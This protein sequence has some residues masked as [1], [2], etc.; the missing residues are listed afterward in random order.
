MIGV[1]RRT[2]VRAR[3][4]AV[5]LVP[6]AAAGVIGGV[7]LQGLA[8]QARSTQTVTVNGDLVRQALQVKYQAADWNGWQTAYAFDA[9]RGVPD[10]AADT[11][12]S[13]TAFLASGKQLSEGLTALA[14]APGLQDDERRLL[15]AAQDAVA[16]F[17][18]ADADV[19]AGYRAGTSAGRAAANELVIGVEI[20]NYTRAAEAVGR[21][22]DQLTAQAVA[23]T[24]QARDD[25][26][27]ARQRVAWALALAV[28]L[29][30][31]VVGVVVVSITRPLRELHARLVD[32]TDG[33]G[34]L[35]A[36]L[37]ETGRD[38]IASV[39]S[40]F[41]RFVRQLADL[42]RSTGEQA[43]A[44][45]AATEELSATSAAIATAA[46]QSAA[47]AQVV[48]SA[49][50]D[51]SG[52]VQAAA[53]GSEQMGAAILEISQSANDASRV[54]ADAVVLAATT[55]AS[56][57]ALGQASVQVGDF[58]KTIN[59]IA[60]QTNLLALNATIEAARA[61]ESGKGFAVVAGEVKELA[62]ET[63]RATDDIA[64]RVQAIQAGTAGAAQAIGE[65][66]AVIDQISQLQ[67]TIAAAVEEQTATTNEMSRNIGRSAAGTDAIAANITDMAAASR[68]TTEGAS[69]SQQAVTE[70][71]RMS[72]ELRGLVS[73]FTC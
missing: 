38:E 9:L 61:G 34:D 20:E 69:Q 2:S 24:E 45:A 48:S 25:A 36:R 17:T 53:A 42:I 70:L 66:V 63:A 16:D 10:A 57:T 32:I 52:S 5:A 73:R 33:E 51:V 72:A 64:Q 55:N 62:R 15:E 3:L 4:V 13:R 50:V 19:A 46:E 67:G 59:G 65:I 8:A 7:A 71:A 12:E 37:D 54:A 29:V 43:T 14:A 35:T 30:S 49:A 22:S 31:V 44:V 68:T 6:L 58:L 23:A 26:S 1:L 60:A 27:A 11:G 47:Q 39:A 41:N 40:T 56:I 28:L 18:A 21:M